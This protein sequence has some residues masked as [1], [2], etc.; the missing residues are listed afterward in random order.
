MKVA[1]SVWRGR[2]APV[3]DVS[4]ELLCLDVVEQ[5]VVALSTVP[6]SEESSR[7]RVLVLLGIETL[8]CGAISAIYAQILE[9]QGIEVIPFVAGDV[10]EVISAFLDGE[11]PSSRLAMPGCRDR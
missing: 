9:A 5:C 3:F 1:L 2:V 6:V 4:R 7:E 10:D 11:L 8:I